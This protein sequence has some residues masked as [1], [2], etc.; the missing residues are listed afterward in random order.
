MTKAEVQERLNFYLD[1]EMKILKGQIVEHNG[2]R[3]TRADLDI[4]IKQRE[5]L[6]RRLATFGRKSHA[7]SSF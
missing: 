3:L 4:I 1:A 5:A 2:K 7:L 6:E